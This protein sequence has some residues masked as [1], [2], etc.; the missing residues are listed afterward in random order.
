MFKMVRAMILVF[1]LIGLSFVSGIG[2][3]PCNCAGWNP[4]TVFW[5]GSLPGIWTGQCGGGPGTI[6]VTPGSAIVIKASLNCIGWYPCNSNSYTWTVT[7]VSGSTEGPWSDS[8]ST[9]SFTP[10]SSGG[11]TIVFNAS[12]NGV[13]CSPCTIYIKIET[14]CNVNQLILNTGYNPITGLVYPQGQQD[15]FWSVVD[16]PNNNTGT[17]GNVSVPIQAWV[18]N[19][20]PL[21]SWAPAQ[22]NSQWI[23]AYQT[24]PN[25]DINSSMYAPN[26]NDHPFSFQRCFFVCRD[27]DN[28]WI[29]L[30]MLVD[31]TADVYF[32]NMLIQNGS[33]TDSSPASYQHPP[34]H[35]G[36]YGATVQ[37]GWH[38]LRVDVRNWGGY[39]GLNITGTVISTQYGLLSDNC[40]QCD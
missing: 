16:A 3:P 40:S 29:E 32:D 38:C 27:N 28:I 20:I 18:F 26:P 11:F 33:Q 1:I 34:Y 37:S 2:C 14:T 24:N 4:V 6:Q 15:G 21:G 5:T 36:P 19:N 35:V 23:S 30:N 17:N 39:M 13:H 7:K 22:T 10:N 25:A 31:N 8:G 9:A 12:C